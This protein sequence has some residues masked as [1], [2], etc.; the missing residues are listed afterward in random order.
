MK[1]YEMYDVSKLEEKYQ[2]LLNEKMYYNLDIEATEKMINEENLH[3]TE[4][5][6]YK[7]DIINDKREIDRLNSEL[8]EIKRVLSDKNR[9]IKKEIK[10]INL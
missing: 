3:Y 9:L 10:F 1:N 2:E 6:E 7:N 5:R 4:L 8:E